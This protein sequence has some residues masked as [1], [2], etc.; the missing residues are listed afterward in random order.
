MLNE[1]KRSLCIGFY[2]CE[3][4]KEIR[5]IQVGN[6]GTIADFFCEDLL[7]FSHIVKGFLGIKY[8]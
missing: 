8:R 1:Q 3:L 4:R 5:E 2:Q 6:A 7:T